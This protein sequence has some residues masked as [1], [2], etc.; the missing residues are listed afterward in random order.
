MYSTLVHTPL[1]LGP[2][3]AS[4]SLLKRPDLTLTGPNNSSSRVLAMALALCLNPCSS[5]AVCSMCPTTNPC[6]ILCT[7]ASLLECFLGPNWSLL[8]R[9]A[10]SEMPVKLNKAVVQGL[11]GRTLS[12]ADRAQLKGPGSQTLCS[13]KASS[14]DKSWPSDSKPRLSSKRAPSLQPSHL[15]SLGRA[16]HPPSPSSSCRLSPSLKGS[17]KGSPKGS[18]KG[19]L[20]SDHRDSNPCLHLSRG[21]AGYPSPSLKLPGTSLQHHSP[22]V[23]LFAPS[24]P[25]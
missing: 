19:S 14:C 25:M 24:I 2:P 17:L 9:L 11:V 13:S 16:R 15:S 22:P 23:S 3:P 6:Q 21:K 4:R 7:L 1:G 5:L 18:L 12:R 10:M 8:D 20:L